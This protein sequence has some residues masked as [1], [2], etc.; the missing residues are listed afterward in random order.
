MGNLVYQ[1]RP[2]LRAGVATEADLV[3]AEVNASWRRPAGRGGA[4][5]TNR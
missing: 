2:Q 5:G 3:I 1:D 4:H